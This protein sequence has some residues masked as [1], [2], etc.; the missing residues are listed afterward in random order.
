VTKEWFNAIC[1]NPTVLNTETVIKDPTENLGA[2][3]LIDRWVEKLKSIDDV[4]LEL[5]WSSHQIFSI[6]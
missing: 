2:D 5:D 6:W 1:P 3:I 4:C